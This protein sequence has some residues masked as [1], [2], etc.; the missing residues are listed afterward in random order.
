LSNESLDH[1][2]IQVSC[3]RR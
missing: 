2:D 3:S 1:A